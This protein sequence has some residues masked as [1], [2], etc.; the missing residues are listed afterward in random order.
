M[1]SPVKNMR[2]EMPDTAEAIDTL[3]NVFGLANV[4]QQIKH[5]MQGLPT[6]Y[7]TENGVEVGTQFVNKS[8]MFEIDG[9]DFLR[10][11]KLCRDNK[12]LLSKGKRNE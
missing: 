1:K 10:M 9:A 4:N 6:F 3:R 8:H 7:A 11:G 12:A 2:L 5:G